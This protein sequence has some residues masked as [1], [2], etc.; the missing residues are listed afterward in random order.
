MDLNSEGEPVLVGFKEWLKAKYPKF[1]ENQ[2]INEWPF[3]K[4]SGPKD[5]L[6]KKTYQLINHYKEKLVDA[7]NDKDIQHSVVP[8]SKEH[9]NLIKSIA[10]LL[11]KIYNFEKGSP[12]L[13]PSFFS[14]T[15]FEKIAR[16]AK[17]VLG[18]HADEIGLYLKKID[19][20][21]SSHLFHIWQPG[22]W[23]GA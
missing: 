19:S 21:S 11:S 12:K 9:R 7:S 10:E 2:E 1:N 20:E 23:L 5:D 15:T 8:I 4:E 3:A 16:Y 17:K 22:S 13:K 14:D 18:Y 6:E